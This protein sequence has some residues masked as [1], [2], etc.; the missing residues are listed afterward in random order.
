MLKYLIRFDDL[1]PTMAHTKWSQI[2]RVMNKYDLKPIV[3]IV[4][5]NKYPGLVVEEENPN[6]WARMRNLQERQWTI[7]LHGFQHLPERMNGGFLPY[8]DKSEF[9]GLPEEKQREKIERALRIF[10][11]KGLRPQLWA[12][13]WHTFDRL[14]IAI[15]KAAGITALS[16]GFSLYPFRQDGMLWIPQQIYKF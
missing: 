2:E 16:D 14:T 4:P 7:A 9:A 11:E 3:A 10:Q 1:C 13:P 15:L 5:D 6:F 8:T 12:A